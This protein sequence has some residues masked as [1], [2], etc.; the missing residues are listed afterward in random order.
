MCWRTFR[1]KPKHKSTSERVTSE[2]RLGSLALFELDRAGPQFKVLG[3][4]GVSS[5]LN[6]MVH[7]DR[8]MAFADSVH[9]QW[10]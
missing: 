5:F 4:T 1:S 3:K 10:R 9:R 2:P 6:R 7:F 8:L